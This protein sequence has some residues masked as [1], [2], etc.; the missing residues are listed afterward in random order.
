MAVYNHRDAYL[1]Q[2]FSEDYWYDDAKFYACELVKQLTTDDWN[3]LKSSWRNRSKQ[4]Q[5]RCA[6]ILDWGDARQAVPLLMEM[7]QVEDDELTL[8]AAD[9]LSSIGVVELDLPV[10]AGVLSRL[11]ALAHSGNVAKLIS[12]QLLAQLQ[13]KGLKEI[14]MTDPFEMYEN[15]RKSLKQFQ[16]DQASVSSKLAAQLGIDKLRIDQ[17]SASSKL[18]RQLGIEQVL[19]S[20]KLVDQ[21]RVEQE[22]SGKLGI[23]QVLGSP[24][25]ADQIW[26]EQERFYARLKKEA[27]TWQKL[28]Q[29]S[30]NLANKLEFTEIRLASIAWDSS[31]T[32]VARRFQEIN[33]LERR[34]DLAARLLEPSKVYTEFVERTFQRIEQ[35]KSTKITKALQTSLH[36]AEEQLLTTTNSL[37]D[38]LTVPEDD[39]IALAPR[40]LILPVVQQDELIAVVEAG[41]YEEDEASL[42]KLPPSAK[43][44]DE[45]RCIL[46]LVAKCNEVV[47]A[48]GKA[49]IFKP[50]TRL[51]EVYADL[52][53][54]FPEDKRTFADFV[55]CLYFIFYEGAGKDKLRFLNDYGGVLDASSDCDFIWCIK[56]LRNKWLRHD[57]DHGKEADIRRS[58]KDLSAKFN[59]L[60]LEHAP[61]T[62][63]HFR[64]LHRSLLREAE[65]FLGKILEKLTNNS[66]E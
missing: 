15:L 41:D 66:A 58:W 16:I 9:S 31:L 11:Q 22:R 25:V 34:S 13:G 3:A 12:N 4:W 8:T 54:L 51:L 35:S 56:H 44:A 57:A 46:S 2:E 60:G 19:G 47:Q 20:S 36:L 14:E 64:H 28:A 49:E 23:E 33:L 32:Q 45:A 29:P 30:Q 6:E 7:I 17:I 5:E 27:A 61:V 53:W 39:E 52:P 50:T 55:D 65:A 21:I 59:L 63:Q 43:V 38:I 42:I 26:A 24:K 40:S 48:A 10:S 62:K 37:S 18:A 1:N